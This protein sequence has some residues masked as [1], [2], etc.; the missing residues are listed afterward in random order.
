MTDIPPTPNLLGIRL[1]HRAMLADTA[2]FAT[3]ARELAGGPCPPRRAR[4]VAGYLGLLCDSIH[5]HHRVEDEVLWP[6]LAAAAGDA[7]DL[8]ELTDDHAQLDPMLAGIRAACADL[9]AGRAG[10]AAH[11][12][13]RL[14]CLHTVLDEHITDEE[15]TVFPIVT[16]YLSPA[17]WGQV[18][19]AARGGAVLRFELPRMMAVCTPAERAEVLRE[20][21]LPVRAMLS[22]F[23]VRHRRRERALAG[24]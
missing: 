10:A 9:V 4:A 6:M 8:R 17:R 18:E 20:G 7:V 2:R 23:G 15:R 22:V 14:T 3:L 19:A 11:L 21:G 12:A 1:A 13:D 5:H 24:G 16:E